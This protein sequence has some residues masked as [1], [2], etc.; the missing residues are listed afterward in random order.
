MEDAESSNKF[1]EL[2][3]AISLR[4][5][6]IKNLPISSLSETSVL[7]LEFPLLFPRLHDVIPLFYRLGHNR[8]SIKEKEKCEWH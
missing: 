8:T 6:K 2:N 5:E 3:N 4:V 1:T 7:T